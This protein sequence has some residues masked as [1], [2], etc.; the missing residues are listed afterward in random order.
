MSIP[1]DSAQIESLPPAVRT[2]PRWRDPTTTTAVATVAHVLLAAAAGWF[3]MQQLAPVVRPLLVAVFLAYILLPYHSR[4]QTHIGAPASIGVLAG[5]TAGV[6]VTLALITYTSLLGLSEDIPR[7]HARAGELLR[8]T[9]V[10]FGQMP[11][12]ASNLKPSTPTESKIGE[13]LSRATGP[14]L[15]MAADVLLETI[16]VAMYLLF[17]LLE[18][19]RF[20][21]RVRRAYPPDR[22]AEILQ[23][24]GQ[25]SSAIVGYLR[26]KVK[27]SLVLAV[28]IGL[29]LWACGVKFAVLWAL[30]T[31]M[32]N[33]I[34]YIGPVVAYS[35][36]V[37]FGF[38]WFGASW[39]PVTVAVLLML[40]HATSAALVEPTMIGNAVGLSPLVLLAALAFWGLLWGIPGMFLAVPLTVVGV[41]VMNHFES[42]RSVAGLLRGV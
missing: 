40:C 32:C 16:V 3:L 26:V 9:E 5:A 4:L 8:S 20:P 30:L 15:S 42:T 25:V 1:S 31:F 38:L 18:G 29:I 17:L 33:F 28:P 36:P 11:R 39:E 13:Q 35:L 27:A 2:V 41:I 22:A 10:A 12:W 7:L 37:G 34:P 19:S 24:A 6:L 21:H 14:V 23:I